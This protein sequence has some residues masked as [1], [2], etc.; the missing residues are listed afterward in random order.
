GNG[1]TI[2]IIAKESLTISGAAG[3]INATTFGEG[4]AGSI[5]IDVGRLTL[6]DGARISTNTFA[7][8]P[9]G[10][11]KINPTESIAISGRDNRTNSTGLISSQSEGG[12][13][14]GR[15]SISAPTVLINEGQISTTTSGVGRAG[16]IALTVGSLTLGGSGQITSATS[17]SGP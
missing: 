7:T 5:E 12:G 10:T 8:G 6:T 15:I 16:D 9:A 2:Q 14:G 13:D 17:G 11:V 1:G 4:K 3:G